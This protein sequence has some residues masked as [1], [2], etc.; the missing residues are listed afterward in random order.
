MEP[1]R[2]TCRVL[3]VLRE[4]EGADHARRSTMSAAV[5][6]LK[7]N[8]LM[9]Y[10]RAAGATSPAT[11]RTT[12]DIGCRQGWIFRRLVA[13]GVFVPVGDGKFYMDEEEARDFVQRRRVKVLLIVA[14]ALVFF[15]VVWIA[16]NH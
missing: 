11:A 3:S 6:H 1:P 4:M 2:A 10:F 13:R 14:V 7:Q 12:K 16:A 8:R 9:R 15:L 5:I